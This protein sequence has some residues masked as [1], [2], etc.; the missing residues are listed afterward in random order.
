MPFGTILFGGLFVGLTVNGNPLHIDVFCALRF[1][2]GLT[3]TVRVNVFEGQA[4]NCDEFPVM[5]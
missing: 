4:P 2:V 3:V 1:G 5:L